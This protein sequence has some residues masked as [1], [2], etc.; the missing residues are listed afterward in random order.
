[1]V[2]LLSFVTLLLPVLL[3]RCSP[4]PV[5]LPPR[6]PVYDHSQR[7]HCGVAVRSDVTRFVVKYA[8]AQ[9]WKPSTPVSISQGAS[10]LQQVSPFPSCLVSAPLTGSTYR[11]FLPLAPSL[12]QVPC[13]RTAFLWLFM[14]PT[15]S[16]MVA[17]LPPSSGEL[18]DP[19]LSNHTALIIL[20]SSGFMVVHS[21]PV[22]RATPQSMALTLPLRPNLLLQLF[23]TGL[24]EYGSICYSDRY[25]AYSCAAWLHG[26]PGRNKPGR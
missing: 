19:A 10:L 13:P 6:G 24:A 16:D 15:P 26:P 20:S 8:N 21:P 22:L 4:V 25:L 14:F 7:S 11:T 17:T 5:E 1:M 2:A 12:A 18:S 3:T 9:R 23:N